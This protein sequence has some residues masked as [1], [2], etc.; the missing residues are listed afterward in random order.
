[1]LRTSSLCCRNRGKNLRLC[2]L[3]TE[4]INWVRQQDITCG[5]IRHKFRTLR[6]C[7]FSY[8]ES[9]A[10]MSRP[11]ALVSWPAK[12][13]NIQIIEH[14][15]Y[16]FPPSNDVLTPQANWLPL[17]WGWTW[18]MQLCK[19]GQSEE[20]LEYLDIWTPSDAQKH[21]KLQQSMHTMLSIA[22]EKLKPCASE[23]WAT[24]KNMTATCRIVSGCKATAEQ[25][26]QQCLAEFLSKVR[27]RKAIKF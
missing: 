9:G 25:A 20:N 16:Q 8:V 15:E 21:L 6:T 26:E 24:L 11:P 22:Q 2:H 14:P 13:P 4:R 1:M 5:N 18:A 23:C 10:T 7:L 3:S 12:Q 27:A 19:L 17:L